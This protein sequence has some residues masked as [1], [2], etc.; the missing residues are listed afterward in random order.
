[1]S[2]SFKQSTSFFG[3]M[4]PDFFCVSK[5]HSSCLKLETWCVATFSSTK[6]MRIARMDLFYSHVWIGTACVPHPNAVQQYLT[7]WMNFD[8]LNVHY[9]LVVSWKNSKTASIVRR[10]SILSNRS[11]HNLR[12][13]LP[14]F[15]SFS[16]RT[17][18]WSVSGRWFQSC[19]VWQSVADVQIRL[20]VEPTHKDPEKKRKR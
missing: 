5:F 15:S 3:E 6:T 7:T 19:T 16:F 20:H 9:V 18:Y 14:V 10:R 1:M 8:M 12:F 17:F 2:F 4:F 13:F 11:V